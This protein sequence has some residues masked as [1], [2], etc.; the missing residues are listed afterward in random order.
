MNFKNKRFITRGI[1][2]TVNP[3]LQILLWGLIDTMPSSKDYLQV[4]ELSDSAGKVKVIHTQENPEYR[5]EYLWDAPVF[6]GK[7]FVIDDGD[8]STMLLAEEYS[9]ERRIFK[10]GKRVYL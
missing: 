2:D 10:Y 7:I 8:H 9:F 4:F 3:Y 1:G 6:C 5:R